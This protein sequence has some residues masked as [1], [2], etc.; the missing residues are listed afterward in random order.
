MLFR[1]KQG[2]HPAIHMQNLQWSHLLG[3]PGTMGVEL[4]LVV[5]LI[6]LAI[7]AKVVSYIEDCNLYLEHSRIS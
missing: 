6:P 2:L 1:S 4:D 7:F 5:L 3:L